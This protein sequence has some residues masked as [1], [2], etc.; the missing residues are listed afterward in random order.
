[1]AVTSIQINNEMF[2]SKDLTV[3]WY[4]RIVPVK[5]IQHNRELQADG[6]YV[7]GNDL[8]VGFIKG[9]KKSNGSITLLV[10]EVA[11][12]ELSLG[13][14]ITD[15]PPSDIVVVLSKPNGVVLTK[16]Y[17]T[18]IPLGEPHE[19]DGDSGD[20]TGITVPLWIGDVTPWAS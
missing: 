20:A 4:G 12:L 3:Y 8:P 1:M 14:N 16:T 6:V 15:A 17:K 10:G 5:K 9:N 18:C 13:K 7:C 19:W 2:N 11:G